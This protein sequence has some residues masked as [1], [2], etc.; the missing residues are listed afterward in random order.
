M[1]ISAH[2][3][4]LLLRVRTERTKREVLLLASQPLRRLV[5]RGFWPVAT[6]SSGV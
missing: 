1:K 6:I 3:A 2:L 4:Q 5:L